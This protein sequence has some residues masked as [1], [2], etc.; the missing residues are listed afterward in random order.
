MSRLSGGRT[1]TVDDDE[2]EF[3]LVYGEVSENMTI[4]EWEIRSRRC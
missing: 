2:P 3:I 1:P 4:L